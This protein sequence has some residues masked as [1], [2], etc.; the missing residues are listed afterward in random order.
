VEHVVVRRAPSRL[1]Y[2]IRILPWYAWPAWPL[3]AWAVWRSRRMLATAQGIVLPLVA[4]G[5][6]LVVALGL[7]RR[8]RGERDAA[9]RPLALLGVAE[10]ETLPRG[11]RERPRLV[12]R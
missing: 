11:G 8:A 1:G 4:F 5:V 9:P 12:R 7:R 3:A 2:F 10:I 6:F